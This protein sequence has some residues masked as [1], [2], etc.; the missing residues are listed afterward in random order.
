MDALTLIFISLFIT[1]VILIIIVLNIIQ[2]MKNKRFKKRLEQLEYEK[3]LIDGTPIMPELSKIE[4]FLKNEKL[5]VMFVDWKDRLHI[6]KST[7]VPKLTDMILEADYSLSKLDYKAA[8]YKTA[9]LEMELY[10]VKANADMLLNEIKKITSSEERN[11]AII[12]KFKTKYR[13]LIQIF[14]DRRIEYGE[15]GNSISLQFE[16]IARRFD[17]FERVMENN[18]YSEV[19][20]IIKALDEMLKHMEVVVEEVPSIELLTTNLIPTKIKQVEDTYRE[21]VENGY[22]L[23]YLNI[24]YN[25]GE[26]N[27]KVSDILDRANVLNLEDSLF[28]LKLLLEYFDNSFNDFEKEKNDR[29]TYEETDEAFRVKLEKINKQIADIYAQIDDVKNIYNLSKNDIVLLDEV[30]QELTT[31][32]NDYKTLI[33]HTRNNTFA[34]SKLTKEIELLLNRLIAV[35]DRL[36]NSLDAIG[37]MKDDEIRARKELEE[38]KRILKESK[39]KIREYNLPVIPKTYFV[40]LA[41]AQAAIKEIIHELDKTPITISVLNTRVDTARDLVLKL[42]KSTKDMM[43]TAMF[44]EMAIVY[45]NRYRTS[46]ED[47]D[48]NLTYSELLFYRGDYSKSLQLTINA[49]NR[50]EPGI[51]EKLLVLFDTEK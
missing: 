31:L 12:T 34:Y 48:K 43:K 28:E 25:I 1:G 41:E 49:L 5:E 46:I 16:N 50:V 3:N 21:M 8:T 14:N 6:I 40:E 32:N 24:E 22:P 15:I 9:K 36:D 10:K 11:R 23:D 26:A 7:Q 37:T 2:S 19:T 42:Y 45:G 33:D 35:E 13:E 17:D 44:A 30:H 4:T 38:V 51:Y 20:Q 39:N 27:K 18:E 29:T 47:L